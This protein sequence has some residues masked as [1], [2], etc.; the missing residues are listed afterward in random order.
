LGEIGKSWSD[1]G[2]VYDCVLFQD[3]KS[4]WRA[5]LDKEESGDLTNAKVLAD[6][7]V[8]FEYD[9]F[10]K[11]DLL[12]YS[13][14]IYNNGNVLSVVANSGS[15]GKFIKALVDDMLVAKLAVFLRYSRRWHC[16]S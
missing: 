2:P 10:S 5:V 4:T 1:L 8:E 3:S 7:A 16:C 9:T 15:H 11:E 6:Y 12:N 14:K 13:V